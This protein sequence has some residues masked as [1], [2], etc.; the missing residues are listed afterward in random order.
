MIE[1]IEKLFHDRTSLV[2]GSVVMAFEEVCPDR[3]VREHACT[4]A[5]LCIV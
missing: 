2:L 1:V 4:A 3:Y 5:L